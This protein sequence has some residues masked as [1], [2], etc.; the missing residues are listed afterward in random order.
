MCEAKILYLI[1]QKKVGLK[2]SSAQILV[3][4]GIF[5]QL[6]STNNFCRRKFGL[7]LKFHVGVKFVFK[8]DISSF[9]LVNRHYIL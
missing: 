9:R 8:Y 3:T 6:V 5:R 2:F 4:L 7:F 1:G